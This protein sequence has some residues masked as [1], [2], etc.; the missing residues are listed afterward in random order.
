MT[1]KKGNKH[2]RAFKR[3]GQGIFK[4]GNKDVR[5]KEQGVG[6]RKARAK[7]KQG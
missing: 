4:K 2:G 3:M 5:E 7:T 1:F 6:T